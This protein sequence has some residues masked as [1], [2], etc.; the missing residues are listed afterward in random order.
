LGNRRRKLE[1]QKIRSLSLNQ[2]EGLQ[3]GERPRRSDVIVGFKKVLLD[4]YLRKG[5]KRETRANTIRRKK[6]PRRRHRPVRRDKELGVRGNLRSLKSVTRKGQLK[7]VKK[8]KSCPLNGTSRP[9]AVKASRIKNSTKKHV[10]E[11]G[12]GLGKSWKRKVK[13]WSI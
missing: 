6:R 3:R 7:K 13:N 8:E 5:E 11:M 10:R 9:G 12:G 1:K 4:F 2:Q